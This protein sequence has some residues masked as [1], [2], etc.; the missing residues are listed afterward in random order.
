MKHDANQFDPDLAAS[1]DAVLA[2]P[3]SKRFGDPAAGASPRPTGWGKLKGYF[4]GGA[5]EAEETPETAPALT[6]DPTSTRIFLFLQSHGLEATPDH[7]QLAW[8]YFVSPLNSLSVAVDEV[9]LRDGKLSAD[10]AALLL[11][12][13]RAGNVAGELAELLEQAK[14]GIADGSKVVR[15][16]RDD[17]AA[18]GDALRSESSRADKKI[19]DIGTLMQLTEAMAVKTAEAERELRGVTGQLARME[20]RVRT[21]ERKAETDA[22]TGLPNRRAFSNN[23]DRAITR[24]RAK[25]LPLTVA[26]C[27][28]DHFKRINDTHGHATGD[29]VLKYVAGMLSAVADGDCHVARHGGEE[30]VMLFRDKSSDKALA[31]VEG[32]REALS[33]KKLIAIDTGL[34]IG[35]VTFSAGLAMLQS[36][37][38]ASDLLHTADLALYRAKHGGR[39]QV[40]F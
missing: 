9:L 25:D 32:V 13:Y 28:I 29:R 31:I 20:K 11:S 33:Q 39:N 16:S 3:R 19:P 15:R 21:A 27:D 5:G 23:L 34:P 26:F 24:S 35:S 1:L 6:L 4:G 8:M 38:T 14:D 18:F 7:F 40:C 10:A 17:V 37:V 36:D 12:E 2:P 30:F 22:L